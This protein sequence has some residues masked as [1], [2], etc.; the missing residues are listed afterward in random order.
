MIS[1]KKDDRTHDDFYFKELNFFLK[2][3]EL[4]LKQKTL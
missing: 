1:E 4:E 3:S 2:T